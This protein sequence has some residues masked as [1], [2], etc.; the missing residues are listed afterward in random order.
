MFIQSFKNEAAD[1]F[2]VKMFACANI[3]I[4]WQYLSVQANNSISDNRYM[5]LRIMSLL[6]AI[7]WQPTTT[8]V[9]RNN[10]SA[11]VWREMTTDW[12][13]TDGKN[14]DE[15]QIYIYYGHLVGSVGSLSLPD[16][17]VLNLPITRTR[18]ITVESMN[19]LVDWIEW[20]RIS[21]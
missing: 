5:R 1:T 17:G 6:M 10:S 21:Q 15:I 11:N 16:H 3:S 7:T 8:A 20:V 13:I 2:P 4:M 14:W 18:I 9:H 19:S 12:N